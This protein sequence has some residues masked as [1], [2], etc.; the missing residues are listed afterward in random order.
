MRKKYGKLLK[1]TT[2]GPCQRSTP[3]NEQSLISDTKLTT[4]SFGG[5][6]PRTFRHLVESVL[7]AVSITVRRGEKLVKKMNIHCWKF[8]YLY[9]NQRPLNPIIRMRNPRL[10]FLRI[11]MMKLPGVLLMHIYFFKEETKKNYIDE[12][13]L[14]FIW[15]NKKYSIIVRR[16]L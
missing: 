5:G 13:P 2:S 11:D 1:T 3:F 7:P 16:Q 15:S 9:I 12:L 6:A 4:F 14:I 8:S 10:I